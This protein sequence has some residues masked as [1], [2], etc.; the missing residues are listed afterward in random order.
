[1]GIWSAQPD[2][3]GPGPPPPVDARRLLWWVVR[4][5]WRGVVPGMVA[6][7]AWMGAIAAVPAVLGQLIDQGVATGDTGALARWLSVL[8]A[9][10]ALR[11]GAAAARHWLAVR[12][13]EQGTFAAQQVVGRAALDPRRSSER[14]FGSGEL[15]SYATSDASRIGVLV[16]LCCRGTGAVVTF[17]AVAVVMLA[18]SPLLGGFVLAGLPPLLL[19]MTPLWRPMERRATAEQ[20]IISATTNLAADTIVGLRVLKGVGGEAPAK[21]RFS[22]ANGSLRHAAVGVARLEAW[23]EALGVVI[24]G[25][26]LVVVAWLGGRLALD[27]S[28]SVGELVAFIGYAQFLATPLATFAEMGETYARAAASAGRVAGLLALAPAGPGPPVKGVHAAVGI[29]ELRFEEMVVAPTLEFPAAL[30]GLDLVVPAGTAVGVVAEDS[31]AATAL[32]ELMG[33]GVHP[34]AGRLTLDGVDVRHLPVATLRHAVLVAHADPFL[35]NRSLADNLAVGDAEPARIPDA[36]AAAALDDVVA[37]LPDGLATVLSERGA[38]LSGGQ[39]QRVGLARALVVDPPVL[40][41]PEPTSAVD[42][43]TE[44]VVIQRL[45]AARAGRTTVVL[46]TSPSLLA[47]LD[48]VVLLLEGRVAATGSHDELV[49]RSSAYRALVSAAVPAP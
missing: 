1:M 35:F 10:G 46:T 33:G 18:T 48:L 30:D 2:A 3:V 24:P 12:L 32:A 37:A 39:R 45:L 34:D 7:I 5:N 27:G 23:W 6:G 41:L 42:A 36:V 21:A 44:A 40:V 29:G 38:S 14:S 49:E 4:S 16:D 8:A 47:E 43:H 17:A 22:V 20:E 15:V 25:S 19:L 11:A 26:F 31:R 9:L 28:I 13:Y